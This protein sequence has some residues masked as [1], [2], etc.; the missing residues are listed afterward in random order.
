M[1]FSQNALNYYLLEGF[2]NTYNILPKNKYRPEYILFFSLGYT[3]IGVLVQKSN[4]RLY[5]YNTD[6]YCL[7]FT[8]RCGR[9]INKDHLLS[10]TKRTMLLVN[11]TSVPKHFFPSL[12]PTV[13]YHFIAPCYPISSFALSLHSQIFEFAH[14]S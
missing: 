9:H 12:Q 1:Q 10:T 13:C 8:V 3:E 2:I 11:A 4:L 6:V 7:L 14:Y 5:I